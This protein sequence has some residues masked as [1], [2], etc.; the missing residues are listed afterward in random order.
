VAGRTTVVAGA[1][2]V[3]RSWDLGEVPADASPR[4]ALASATRL[5]DDGE[6]VGLSQVDGQPVVVCV[7]RRDGAYVW[8]AASGDPSGP[9]HFDISTQDYVKAMALGTLAGQTVAAFGSSNGF[10]VTLRD[11][12][13]GQELW[14]A[15]PDSGSGIQAVAIAEHQGRQ[16]VVAG[17][18][19]GT[20]HVLDALGPAEPAVIQAAGDLRTM[21]VISVGGRP[22]AV[23]GGRSGLVR[24]VDLA[25]GTGDALSFPVNALAVTTVDGKAV[26][27]CGSPNGVRVLS[28]DSGQPAAPAP[29]IG[30]EVLD[31]GVGALHG[32]PVGLYATRSA[33]HARYLDTGE[34]TG[35]RPLE[36]EST[37]PGDRT[38]LTAELAGRPVVV[39]GGHRVGAYDMETGE[40]VSALVE[41]LG[42]A[43][44]ALGV[45]TVDGR[46]VL[47]TATAMVVHAQYLLTHEEQAEKKRREEERFE[48]LHRGDLFG[49]VAHALGDETPPD[50]PR[51]GDNLSRAGAS[52]T[53]MNTGQVDG[54][55]IVVSGRDN[56]T[57]DVF[58]AGTALPAGV[59][60]LAHTT[61]VMAVASGKLC[62]RPVVVSGAAD[63]TVSVWDLAS[64]I[65]V[66]VVHTLSPVLALALA[67][68]DRCVIGTES[69]P[70]VIRLSLP[71]GVGSDARV[72]LPKDPRATRTCP[73]H[74]DLFNVFAT[75]DG[76]PVMRYCIKGVQLGNPTM[77]Q[78]GFARGHCYLLADRFRIAEE[79]QP[80]RESRNAVVSVSQIW[81]LEP[82][83]WELAYQHDGGHFRLRIDIVGRQISLC[84]YTRQM[85]DLFRDHLSNYWRS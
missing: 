28:V 12:E 1:G 18:V 59:P 48:R 54:T 38:L 73:V 37:S 78:L 67:P 16:L 64:Q 76:E 17:S 77:H 74:R 49:F 83:D 39:H 66:I 2:N 45:T 57:I 60:L 82:Q 36:R 25:A 56:G 31:V 29:Q 58:T 8:D 44:H 70:S 6:V 65:Q 68:P 40:L 11:L 26:M 55:P 63:G 10:G 72:A 4:D 33:V 30:S 42:G 51:I 52:P 62:G 85:R 50:Q 27:L 35:M 75:D 80:E 34:P 69:G 15:R 71:S 3:V 84:F 41:P 23:Y 22:V 43:A 5:I 13:S 20:I 53:S 32:R 19:T 81:R 46:T 79:D 47:V 61:P 21:A 7:T 14:S 24:T 9:G